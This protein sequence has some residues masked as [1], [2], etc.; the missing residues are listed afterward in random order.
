MRPG[1]SF[2]LTVAAVGSPTPTFQWTLNG[3]TI[4]GAV[5][6]T[7]GVAS[8]GTGDAGSYAVVASNAN[9]SVTSAAAVVVVNVLPVVTPVT[10][11]PVTFSGT[12]TLSVNVTATGAVTYQWSLNGS[13]IPGA[14]SS[15][16]TT[17]YPG[18]YSVLV[19]DPYGSSTSGMTVAAASKLSNIS[20]RADILTGGNVAIPGFAIN[21]PAGSTKQ[22]LIRAVGPT[23]GGFGVSG[24]IA[25][26]ELVLNDSGGAPMAT[27]IGWTTAPVIPTAAQGGSAL[28]TGS[29]PAATIRAATVADFNKVGAFALGA[30][31]LD[32][33][34]VATLPPGGYTVTVQGVGTGGNQSTGV[35]LA[36]VYEMNS[37]DSAV[38]TNISTRAF[39]GAQQAQAAIPGIVVSGSANA[40]LLIRGIGP[41]LGSFGVSGTITAPILEVDDSGGTTIATNAAWNTAPVLGSSTVVSGSS[42]TGTVRAA[43]V[44]DFNATGAFALNNGSLDAA[45]VVYLPPG[46]YTAKVSG[47]AGGTGATLVEVYQMP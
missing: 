26:P 20:T 40:R 28:V 8:A 23:L 29:S 35:G 24:T 36:E 17:S 14:T 44:A 25:Q 1:A 43:T 9:G 21:G 3:T 5:S 41:T 4:G 10:P 47:T 34:V 6:S 32:S 30:T 31:S 15:T 38:L 11:A 33:A 45:M 22:L 27:S 16:Y 7:Y 46:Q 39:V 37:G 2:S 12:T 13:A 18:S 19:T 42:P